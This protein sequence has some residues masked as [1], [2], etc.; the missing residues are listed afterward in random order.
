MADFGLEGVLTVTQ[1]L[2]DIAG[3]STGHFGKWHIGPDPPTNGASAEE[4]DGGKLSATLGEFD[5]AFRINDEGAMAPMPEGEAAASADGGAGNRVPNGSGA[6]GLGGSPRNS[7]KSTKQGP[8]LDSK[9]GK[10]PKSPK[11]GKKADKVRYGID[12]V[13]LI[14]GKRRDK[15]G[16]DNETYQA[17]MKFMK[18]HV[19]E[20][21]RRREIRRRRM[22]AMNATN[23]TN[24]E[25][26]EEE[27]EV[28]FYVNVWG[29]IPHT[30]IS[31]PPG[32][33]ELFNDIDVNLDDFPHHMRDKIRTFGSKKRINEEMREYLAE[34]WSVDRVVGQ[35]L[36]LLEDLGVADDTIVVFSSD[37]GASPNAMGSGGFKQGGK[38]SYHQGGVNVPFIVKWTTGG[39]PAGAVNSQ[40]LISA[41]DWTPTLLSL[42]NV[43]YDSAWFEGENISDIWT[44]D[45]STNARSRKNPL[46]WKTSGKREKMAM[47]YDRWKLHSDRGQKYLYDLQT[48]PGEDNNLFFKN[49]DV[50]YAMLAQLKAW[51]KSLPDDYCSKDDNCKKMY[52]FDPEKNPVVVG[53][54]ALFKL[55]NGDE[56][57]VEV[58]D[59]S[60]SSTGGN[61][62]ANVSPSASPTNAPTSM[63]TVSPTHASSTVP[64]VAPSASPTI[65]PTGAPTGAPI[66]SPTSYPTSEPTSEPTYSPTSEPTYSPTS[67]PS[68]SPSA[69]PTVAPSVLPSSGPTAF[70][71]S[72]PTAVP[73]GLPTL[74]PTIVPT[75]RPS[76][77]L[78]DES[79]RD[80]S[81][82]EATSTRSASSSTRRQTSAVSG[83]SGVVLSV[84]QLLGAC[85]FW[86]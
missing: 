68:S 31:A 14:G 21:R 58:D 23:A 53:P 46:F 76:A 77:S 36:D 47:I 18:S 49:P 51:Q 35:M 8:E 20:Q 40:S 65:V 80:A 38:F 82:A 34:I 30:P 15:A 27:E 19:E 17:A 10:H 81:V 3:Y 67:E 9:S 1:M 78:I 33:T 22:S 72:A 43:E 28:P 70:P 25:Q 48:D 13:S 32:L 4:G 73:S 52:S 84:L 75:S 60:G 69:T 55:G 54:P 2:R 42:A 6:N 50:G 71:S 39:V 26:D 57:G 66:D 62:T 85:W 74:A 63:P 37:Q 83:V 86:L 7:P 16:R 56:G 59:Q 61:G 5:S 24:S 79:Q 64:T 44:S 12:T 29:H 45:D 11:R 41:L